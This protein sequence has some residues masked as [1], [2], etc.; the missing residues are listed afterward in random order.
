VRFFEKFSS[1]DLLY[2][3]ILSAIG[4]A[5]KSIVTP[6][7]RIVSAPLMVPGGSLA[8]GIYML[9]I[10]LAI[11]IVRKPGTGILVGVI[12]GIAVLALGFFGNHGAVSLISYSLPGIAAEFGGLFFKQKEILTAQ[13]VMCVLANVSGT[14]VVTLFVLRLAFIPLMIAVI[15]SVLSGILGGIFSRSI[16]KKLLQYRLIRITP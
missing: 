2:I 7:V 10:V 3:A 13:V 1:Q 14:I 15:I 4:L 12:Q 9:W 5:V 16:L 11:G 6:F 8:G